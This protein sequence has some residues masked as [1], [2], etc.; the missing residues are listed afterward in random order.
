MKAN[1]KFNILD[2]NIVTNDVKYCK[3]CKTKNNTK[4]KFCLECGNTEFVLSLTPEKTDVKYC[5]KCGTEVKKSVKFCIECGC[6]EFVLELDNNSSSKEKEVDFK[7]NEELN[8]ILKKIDKCKKEI[9]DIDK[10]NLT[11]ENN[12]KKEVKKW[13]ASIKTLKTEEEQSI[14]IVQKQTEDLEKYQVKLDSLKEEVKKINNKIKESNR[15]KDLA[16]NNTTSLEKT[17]KELLSKLANVK[18]DKTTLDAKLAK[19]E[20][21]LEDTKRKKEQDR[22][23]AEAEKERRIKEAKA[24]EEA[25]AAELKRLNSPEGKYPNIES[26]WCGGAFNLVIKDLEEIA[27]A[28]YS[29]SYL[30]LGM[31]YEY[32]YAVSKSLDKAR[33]W[34]QKSAQSGDPLGRFKSTNVGLKYYSSTDE[35][36][37]LKLAGL[38]DITAMMTLGKLYQNSNQIGSMYN[39]RNW[40]DKASKRNS[41]DGGEAAYLAG[42]CSKK[43]Y[44]SSMGTINYYIE[45]GYRGHKISQKI[46]ADAY[47][48]TNPALY[49]DKKD[50]EKYQF[51]MEK[52]KSKW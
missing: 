38:E 12:I 41:N 21:Q 47:K 35:S 14:I 31:A 27:N 34:Y 50:P 45:A 39:A 7:Y 3:K 32:G 42:E 33:S 23:K 26:K 24:K 37:L 4:A 8:K 9:N 20:K 22:I 36:L 1:S 6:N 30:L 40:Y 10:A 51:W 48:N 49:V 15:K 16:I 52:Y 46:L 11:I 43:C 29:K 17:N 28:G 5:K 44:G 25:L 2:D 13:E 18:K 19:F